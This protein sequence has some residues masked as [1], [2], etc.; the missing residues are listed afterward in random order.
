MSIILCKLGLSGSFLRVILQTVL[1]KSQMLQDDESVKSFLSQAL[2][3]LSSQNISCA[4]K[5]AQDYRS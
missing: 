2:K 4:Q 1:C 3:S 5:E